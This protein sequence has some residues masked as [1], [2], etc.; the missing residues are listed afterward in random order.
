MYIVL[1]LKYLY[2]M[3]FMIYGCVRKE[4]I[5]NY[6]GCFNFFGFRIMEGLLF[7]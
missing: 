3:W 1:C 2:C 4:Y 6:K 5:E 7:F